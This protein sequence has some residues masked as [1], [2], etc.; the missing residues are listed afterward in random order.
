[1]LNVGG[2]LECGLGGHGKGLT[3]E[4]ARCWEGWECAGGE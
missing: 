3:E 1:M 4:K 2:R